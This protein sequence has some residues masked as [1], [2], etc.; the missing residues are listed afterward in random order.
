MGQHD[1]ILSADPDYVSNGRTIPVLSVDTLTDM[2][3]FGDTMPTATA[4]NA[5][6]EAHIPIFIRSVFQPTHPGTYIQPITNPEI[7]D[8]GPIVVQK[9]V[10]TIRASGLEPEA[11]LKALHEDR[12]PVATSDNGRT[13]F[14]HQA[15]LNS[16]HHT[17]SQ[18]FPTANLQIQQ[19][20]NAL[21]TALGIDRSILHDLQNG[22]QTALDN[23][24]IASPVIITSTGPRE[25]T[26]LSTFVPPENIEIVVNEIHH[27]ILK[28]GK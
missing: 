12:I 17:L 19:E 16:A 10:G 4:L 28:Q 1:G 14:V 27:L 20:P 3:A 9:L 13:F 25:S 15:H 8:T 26:H 23:I 11:G 6:I 22:I 21:V 7:A 24:G 2:V 5:V 18:S